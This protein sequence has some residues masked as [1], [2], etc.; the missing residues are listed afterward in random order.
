MANPA[1]AIV[2]AAARDGHVRIAPL[3]EDVADTARA[4]LDAAA[5]DESRVHTVTD[6]PRGV[7]FE[8]PAEVARDAGFGDPAPADDEHQDDGDTGQQPAATA[9]TS[10]PKGNAARADW[11]AWLDAQDPPVA[12]TKDDG[13]DELRELWEQRAAE[14]ANN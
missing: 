1:D 6:T 10:P 8:V 12:Y 14:T 4:L 5:P 13:R 9:P 7:G 3:A 11:A 2:T